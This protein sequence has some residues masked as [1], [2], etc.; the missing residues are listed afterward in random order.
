MSCIFCMIAENKIP[1]KLVYED[2][3]IKAFYDIEPKAPIHC[4]IISKN[5][6][7]SV[8]SIDDTNSDIIAHIFKKIPQ[9]AK[10][11]G[12]DGGYRVVSN[13]GDNAG[14]SVKH[15]HF[16]ILGGGKLSLDMA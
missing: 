11:L 15:L 14:Q 16:H 10:Q 13:I 3:I 4:L 9:I 12:L 6:I 5:H 2:E 7:E 8:N 1:T